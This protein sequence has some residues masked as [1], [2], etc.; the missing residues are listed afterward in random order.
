[1][2][3]ITWRLDIGAVVQ[4]KLR[5]VSAHRSQCGG[6]IDDDPTGFTLPASMLSRCAEPWELYYEL[7]AQPQPQPPK[8][9]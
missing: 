2:E 4:A 3:A 1:V 7:V 6:V 8:E 9:Q 5:A